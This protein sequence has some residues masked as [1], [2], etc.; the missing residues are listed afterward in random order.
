MRVKAYSFPFG[1]ADNKFPG[2]DTPD[3]F[4]GLEGRPIE[5]LDAFRTVWQFNT[6]EDYQKQILQQ[7]YSQA[8]LSAEQLAA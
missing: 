3:M 8:N 2:I 7:M 4:D 6:A 5:G 1:C